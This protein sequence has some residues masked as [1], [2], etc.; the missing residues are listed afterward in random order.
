MYRA[1]C[2][3]DR[4]GRDVTRFPHAR[5]YHHDHE[6]HAGDVS[7]PRPR[8]PESYLRPVRARRSV[9]SPSVFKISITGTGRFTLPQSTHKRPHSHTLCALANLA[10]VRCAGTAAQWRPAAELRTAASGPS[11]G[12]RLAIL[13][14][15]SPPALSSREYGGKQ[16]VEASTRERPWPRSISDVE[17]HVQARVGSHIAAWPQRRPRSRSSQW[18]S[19]VRQ[20]SSALRARKIEEHTS[21]ASGRQLS[22]E[23]RVVSRS[24]QP[25]AGFDASSIA[26]DGQR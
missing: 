6:I 8:V 17:R 11:D 12:E 20:R 2:S 7:I 4:R 25:H 19:P 13:V 3:R 22:R 23:E 21:L 26:P 15:A 10:R 16:R 9:T 5:A 18:P 1:P 24:A 14:L